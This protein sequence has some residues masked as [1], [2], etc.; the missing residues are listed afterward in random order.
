MIGC[1]SGGYFLFGVVVLV[2]AGSASVVF[3]GYRYTLVGLGTTRA[4]LEASIAHGQEQLILDR[5][6]VLREAHTVLDDVLERLQRSPAV[7]AAFL[8][9]ASDQV[10]RP[11]SHRLVKQR[12]GMTP[13]V[14]SS[15]SP[16][17]REV[18][19]VLA[20]KSLIS[21]L[22]L[23]IAVLFL[24]SRLTVTSAEPEVTTDGEFEQQGVTISVDLVSLG[25]SLIQLLIVFLVTLLVALAANSLTNKVLPQLKDSGKWV[26]QVVSVLTVALFSQAIIVSLFVLAGFPVSLVFTATSSALIIGL[27]VA[28]SFF[29][30]LI[31]SVDASQRDVEGQLQELNTKLE[32]TLSRLGQKLWQQRRELG[33]LLHGN[34]RSTLIA[35]AMQLRRATGKP[36]EEEIEQVRQRLVEAKNQLRETPPPADPPEALTQLTELWRGTCDIAVD[37]DEATTSRLAS[38][39]LAGQ[40]T[41]QVVDE[42]CASAITHGHAHSIRINARAGDYW[43]DI[44]VNNDGESLV[45][46]V[47]PGLGSTLLDEVATRWDLSPTPEGTRLGARLPLQ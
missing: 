23:A 32:W 36:G 35:S 46:P 19:A 12:P 2:I 20:K 4:S 45:N 13:P 9:E 34:V 47:Q 7:A 38:D 25:Q 6:D 16:R 21:P 37:I 42:A 28:V 10:V 17:W 15:P 24:S 1:S 22:A 40:S 11:F 8:T 27:V 29:V 33:V 31:R 39:A 5:E 43:L 3:S 30:G 44:E 18:F 26:V 41:I 14:K